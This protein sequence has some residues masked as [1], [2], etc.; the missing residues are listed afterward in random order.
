VLWGNVAS[1]LAGAAGMI[2]D[3]APSHA[4]RAAGVVG[5]ML[6]TGPLTGTGTLVRPSAE[7]PRQFLIRHNCCLYYR[8]PGGGTCGDCVLTP[9]EERRRGWEAVLK[10]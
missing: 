2:A 3:R 7:T 1:A 8:I 5:E 4:G 9:E 10:R 6:R